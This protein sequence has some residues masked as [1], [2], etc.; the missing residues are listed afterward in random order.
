MH[1]GENPSSGYTQSLYVMVIMLK[2]GDVT[3]HRKYKT[4]GMD[5][6]GCMK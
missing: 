2:V 1:W 3:L 5:Y 4:G 6:T